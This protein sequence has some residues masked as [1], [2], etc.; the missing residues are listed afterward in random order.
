M[1]GMKNH[2]GTDTMTQGFCVFPFELPVGNLL[3][4][5]PPSKVPEDKMV[6]AF[7]R[8]HFSVHFQDRLCQRKVLELYC[9]G[10]KEVIF[11]LSQLQTDVK[12]PMA[13]PKA[14]ENHLL[15]CL[16]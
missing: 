2:K 3:S 7:P 8:T 10:R 9:E 16:E 4:A 15:Y 14:P 12:F 6:S 5:L 1:T 13:S 11:F